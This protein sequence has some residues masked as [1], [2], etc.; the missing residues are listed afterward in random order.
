MNDTLARFSKVAASNAGTDRLFMLAQYS[1]SLLP[2]NTRLSK[3]QSLI[4]DYRIFARLLGYPAIHTWAVATYTSDGRK[5]RWIQDAQVIV[6][7]IYQ[8]LENLA[9]LGQHGILPISAE[10]QTKLWLESARC[11]AVHVFLELYRLYLARKEF[12]REKKSD[13]EA[14]SWCR[15]V[16]INLA[17]APLTVHWS[18][19]N[20]LGLSNFTIGL[21]G[22][23]AAV[24]Q[25][26]KC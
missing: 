18:L 23:I 4:S 19:R 24:G 12:L 6:N 11:W 26:S 9:Y 2:P 1:I 8:P 16:V 22:T 25:L 17:Y 5:N 3:L 15:E 10:W 7:L 20:G 14:F 13:E 21:L